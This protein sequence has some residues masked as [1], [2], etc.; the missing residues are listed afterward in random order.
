MYLNVIYLMQITFWSREFHKPLYMY[1][2]APVSTDSLYAVHR[3][4]KKSRKI[5]EING[6]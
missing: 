6:S 4:P 1:S 5:R 3:R 2:R